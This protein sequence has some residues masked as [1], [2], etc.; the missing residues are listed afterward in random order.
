MLKYFSGEILAACIYGK[1]P[2]SV[3]DKLFTQFLWYVSITLTLSIY[4]RSNRLW[5]QHYAYFFCSPKTIR[6]KRSHQVWY[7]S[8]TN[9][10]NIWFTPHYCM[11]YRYQG[12]SWVLYSGTF[13]SWVALAVAPILVDCRLTILDCGLRICVQWLVDPLSAVESV[14]D[15]R[16]HDNWKAQCFVP[17]H[18]KK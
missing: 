14:G 18:A 5:M 9:R 13:R 16:V 17:Y 4:C 8:N 15:F 6:N 1:L 2:Q 12:S 7:E 11:I 10:N 3:R